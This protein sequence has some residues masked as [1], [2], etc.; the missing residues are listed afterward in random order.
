MAAKQAKAGGA[1]KGKGKATKTETQARG[2]RAGTKGEQVL[3]LLKRDKGATIE[4]LAKAV[5]WQAHSVRGFM[6]GTLKKKQGLT[7]RSE[8]IEGR[9]RVYSIA[10]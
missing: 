8:K 10:A 6:S 9:G 1:G 5:R 4:E 7:I 3:G 2:P